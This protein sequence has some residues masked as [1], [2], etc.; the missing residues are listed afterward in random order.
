MFVEGDLKKGT[1]DLGFYFFQLPT[2]APL[3]DLKVLPN[4]LILLKLHL[5]PLA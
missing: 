1:L 5:L 3:W 4:A 2:S